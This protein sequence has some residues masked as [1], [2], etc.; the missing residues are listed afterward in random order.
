MGAG[1]GTEHRTFPVSS[2]AQLTARPSTTSLEP[3]EH[4]SFAKRS[5]QASR[6]Q[7]ERRAPSAG[8]RIRGTRAQMAEAGRPW[9][10]S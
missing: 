8:K 4:P 10:R 2:L 9:A 7:G 1:L 5:L 6:D 3:K